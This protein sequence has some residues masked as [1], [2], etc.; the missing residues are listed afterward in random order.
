MALRQDKRCCLKSIAQNEAFS[1]HYFTPSKKEE[2]NFV[3]ARYTGITD[4]KK[5]KKIL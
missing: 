2:K 1:L 5:R 3:I 4:E